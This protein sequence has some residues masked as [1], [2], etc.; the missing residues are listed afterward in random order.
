MQQEKIQ[1]S[2]SFCLNIV[3]NHFKYFPNTLWLLPTKIRNPICAIYAFART[4]NDLADKGTATENERLKQIDKMAQNLDTIRYGK[5]IEDP[6]FIAL[7]DT[8][9]K[10]DLPI[11]LLHDLLI[12][13]RMDVTVHRYENF[14]D[15]LN[16]CKYSANPIGQ[17]LLYL[18]NSVSVQN[19]S[20]SNA[21]CSAL[22]LINILLH[23]EQ[24][25]IEQG[26]IYLPLNDMQKYN[27]NESALSDKTFSPE[28]R[29][30]IESLL[31]RVQEMLN[32]GKPLAKE[33]SGRVGFELK[34]TVTSANRIIHKI[35]SNQTDVFTQQKLNWLDIIWVFKHALFN[36]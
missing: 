3:N 1:S 32:S 4:A 5:T 7:S 19:I 33:L 36:Y 21:I 26:I 18:F 31:V 10:F 22:Q 24:D 20:Y 23:V 6:I 14:D 25:Y 11:S 27:I 13:P 12:A 9:E 34:L 28:F 35:S 29:Q 15:L 16:Y 8:I 30:L 17:L 2:Y